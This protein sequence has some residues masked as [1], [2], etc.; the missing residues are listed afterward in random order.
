MGKDKDKKRERRQK[1][2]KSRA[3]K[4]NDVRCGMRLFPGTL[5]KD[6][7]AKKAFYI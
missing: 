3:T 6:E 4:P 1:T 2:G 5:V 7:T